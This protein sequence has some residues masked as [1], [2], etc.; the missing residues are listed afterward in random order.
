MKANKLHF[1]AEKILVVTR[2]FREENP[3]LLVRSC[4]PFR[5]RGQFYVVQWILWNICHLRFL[6][7]L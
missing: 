4:S 2:I 1:I 7:Y 6:S 5:S 3:V